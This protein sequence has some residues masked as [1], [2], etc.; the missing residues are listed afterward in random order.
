[1][2]KLTAIALACLLVVS[3]APAQS[4]SDLELAIAAKRAGKP[5]AARR[6][7]L[8]TNTASR[9]A[10]CKPADGDEVVVCGA[11]QK[12]YG[13]D[14]A[15]MKAAPRPLA[16]RRDPRSTVNKQACGVGHDICGVGVIPVTAIALKAGE[17][18]VKAIK[19]D[20][21]KSVFKNGPDEYERYLAEKELQEARE[22]EIA[23]QDG[24]RP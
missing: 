10:D 18:L 6:I 13:P 15:V 14:P 19:G 9:S 22:R 5:I 12:P 1:V 16:H 7:N 23:E 3:E 20:D 24:A 2:L 11:K 8:D 17:A 4:M 21:W